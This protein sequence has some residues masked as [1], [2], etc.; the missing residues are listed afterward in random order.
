MP[1]LKLVPPHDIRLNTAVPITVI[2]HDTLIAVQQ[3]INFL[4]DRPHAYGLAANQVGLELNA[5]VLRNEEHHYKVDVFINPS[6]QAKG[7]KLPYY[8][9]KNA[10]ARKA[11]FYGEGCLTFPGQQFKVKRYE[12][13]NVTYTDIHGKE[14]NENYKGFRAVAYQH[15]LDHLYGITVEQHPDAY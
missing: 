6:F 10:A 14:H 4:L 11:L 1:I 2:D 7:V 12:N 5:F 13:I 3:M 9:F 8:M 15:E